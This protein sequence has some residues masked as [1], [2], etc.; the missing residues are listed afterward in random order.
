MSKKMRVFFSPLTGRAYAT[1]EYEER[2]NGTFEVTG[3]KFDVT[4]DVV[5][6]LM[7]RA[8]AEGWNDCNQADEGDAWPNPYRPDSQ[9]GDVV[10]P[11]DVLEK[12]EK[13]SAADAAPG[14]RKMAEQR[15][16]AVDRND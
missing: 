6:Q 11:A 7:A 8:W 12:I 3:E 16:R 15:R 2:A 4:D 9:L 5:E 10:I 13:D 14:L 1:C